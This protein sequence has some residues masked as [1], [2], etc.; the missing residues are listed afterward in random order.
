M[1]TKMHRKETILHCEKAAGLAIIRQN[2]SST[3]AI[4]DSP[5]IVLNRLE[6]AL[7]T[8]QTLHSISMV[9]ET[10][11]ANLELK[12]LFFLGND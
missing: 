2:V 11:T 12:H 4:L 5:W 10:G 3:E 1:K 6:G 7:T 8:A 9:G